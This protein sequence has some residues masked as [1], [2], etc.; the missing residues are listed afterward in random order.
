MKLRSFSSLT[1]VALLAA[2]GGA[3][4]AGAIIGDG[5]VKLGVDDL[6]QLNI[7]GVVPSTGGGETTVGV[8]YIPS[9][10]LSGSGAEYESTSHGCLCEGWGVAASGASGYANN[11][12]GTAGLVQDSFVSTATTATVVTTATAANVKVT[13]DFALSP[14]TDNLYKVTVTIEALADVT[15][16]EYRRTMDWDADPTPFN[17]L[18]TIGGTAAATNVAGASNDGFSS[19]DPLSSI[20]GAFGI[21]SCLQ[22]DFVDQGYGSSNDHGANFDFIFGDLATGET[23]SFDIFYG[24]ADNVTDAFATMAAAGVEVYSL[25]RSDTDV[26]GDGFN[27]S[28]GAATPTFIFGFAGVGGVVVEPGPIPVPAPLALMAIGLL[29]VFASKRLRKI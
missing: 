3:A 22:G 24:G 2:W 4:Q 9:G 17:E 13:H 15:N 11:A 25:G 1:G 5:N 23:A 7:A 18:V 27:D 14:D 26:D 29:G 10:D 28:T 8:R 21:A 6:A 12:L 16:V 19:S 20:C